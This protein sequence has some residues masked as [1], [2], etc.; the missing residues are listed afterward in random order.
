MSYRK[1]GWIGIPIFDLRGRSS[2]YN[3][4]ENQG[5]NTNIIYFAGKSCSWKGSSTRKW[6]ISPE[7]R[8]R[9]EVPRHEILCTTLKIRA[10]GKAHRHEN[11]I[12]YRK[13][14]LDERYLNTKNH[15]LYWKYVLV[16]RFTD[17]KIK[18]F[19][20]NSCQWRCTSTRKIK[21]STENTC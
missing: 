7:I 19:T 21:Y 11:H 10:R 14:V 8:V 13:F 17:T 2:R 4:E 16:D 18:Y 20:E 9:W 3:L 15:V 6:Y 1:S 5:S 12:F